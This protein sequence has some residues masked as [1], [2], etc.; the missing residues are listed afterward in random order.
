MNHLIQHDTISIAW[1]KAADYLLRVGGSSYN[2]IVE[3]KVPLSEH[4]LVR[5]GL[6]T[7]L[8]SK[9]DQVIETV[10][11]TIFPRALY[12]QG[13]E[14]TSFYQRFFSIY[15]LIRRVPDNR[16]GTYF[17]RMVALDHVCGTGIENQLEQIIRKYI[18][19]RQ[20]DHTG[21][22]YEL[23]IYQ[24]G[25]DANMTMGFPCMSYISFSSEQD[26]LNLNAYYRNQYFVKK[27]YGN[28][29]GLSRL[30]AYVCTESGYKIGRLTCTATHAT[31]ESGFTQ[32]L[33]QLI[34][35]NQSFLQ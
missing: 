27:A 9:Q 33:R 12:R 24:P 14:R 35:Q 11:S 5:S 15:P 2:L 30:L 32:S 17:G 6:D 7:I 3:I 13:E 19:H 18:R 8:R 23:P 16:K 1:L 26:R 20:E 28:Y 21:V 31:L 29:L 22:V 25:K 10:A 34:A 4:T